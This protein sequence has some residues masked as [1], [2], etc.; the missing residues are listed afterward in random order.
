MKEKA[1]FLL[2]S[3]LMTG[4]VFATHL[5]G[6]EMNYRY[7]GNDSF[8]ITLK[9]YRD[10]YNGVA[11]FDNPAN[12][13][14]FDSNNN[15]YTSFEMP[16]DSINSIANV[17]NSP[18]L[19][20]PD[21]VCYEVGH[22]SQV[23]YLP[24]GVGGYQVAYQRCCR[25]YTII[26]IQNPGNVGSTIVANIPDLSFI[27]QDANPVFKN[28]P[29]TFIC[30]GAPFI[31]DH[32]ATDADGD[33]LMYELCLPYDG[34][35]TSVPMPSVPSPPP[36]NPIPY[37][38]P[39]SINNFLGGTPMTINPVTG[40][41]R[42][43]PASEG[44]FVYGICVK[45][46]RNGVYIGETRR[47]FQVNVTLCSNITVAG[48]FSP[49]VS[50]G[51]LTAS[52]LNLSYGAGFYSWSFGNPA[53][54]N[55]TS[56]A[57]NPSYSYTDTGTYH[58][59]LVAYSAINPLCNDTDYGVVYVYP[60]FNSLFSINNAR[61]S[62]FFYFNDLSYGIDGSA[63][64]WQWNFGDGYNIVG[65]QNPVHNY[66]SPGMYNVTLIAATDSGC[67]DTITKIINVLPVP[68][69]QF[70]LTLD[71]CRMQIH[72][73]NASTQSSNY[74]WNFGDGGNTLQSNNTYTY[75]S[76][77]SFTIQLIA[78]SDS[79]CTD[80]SYFSI[81]IPQV[82]IPDFT[83]SAANCDSVV[84]FTNLSLNSNN[85]TWD[86][87]D[88][89]YAY[90]TNPAHLY[91]GSGPYTVILHA[92]GNGAS[93]SN[94]FQMTFTL[95]RTPVAHFNPLLDTCTYKVNIQNQSLFASQYSWWISDGAVTLDNNSSHQFTSA[96]TY[97]IQMIANSG[98]G[99]TDTDTAVI[100]IP[101][102]ARADYSIL[103][104]VCDSAA[105]FVNRSGNAVSYQWSFGD[106]TTSSDDNPVQLVATSAH[107]CRDTLKKNL[108]LL[109]R[110]PADFVFFT[111]TCSSVTTFNNRSPLASTFNWDFGDSKQSIESN[112]SH[113][114]RSTKNY[115]V[116]FITNEG[117]VCEEKTEKE[118]NFEVREGEI[119]SIPNSFTPN[120][121]GHNDVFRVYGYR[122]CEV[123][124]MSIFDR[125]GERVFETEDALNSEWDGSFRGAIVPE[126]VYVY[127]LT[128]KTI[129]RTGYIV[130]V[131]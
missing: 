109:F 100:T 63:D 118:L 130:V 41:V 121:D 12:I 33:S 80:T 115:T 68:H 99:C 88:L 69:S 9:I 1:L 64:F 75:S 51:T 24:Q 93:C 23:V 42:A 57:A 3:I 83:Y 15:L 67:T 81:A 106:A 55:D 35:S 107:Q 94:D 60:K 26:N 48:I 66:I 47:E 21:N 131:K 28:L 49:T 20:P 44:Q 22:Y 119:I 14:V 95:N 113:I 120:K 40:Q 59:Q 11:P 71:T 38:S 27:G 16:L 52:F 104:A 87:G 76:N 129:N 53:T 6:G 2:L 85:Y 34:A 101:P 7:L 30:N 45:E 124:S 123:Y 105:N 96:G 74:S 43:V 102:K 91:H 65:T 117:T 19:I 98:T 4:Q 116:T 128:A 84:H 78:Q 92:V 77:G 125:W 62:D 29:P 37:Q 39:Y 54:N 82:P 122:P 13:G 70:S 97:S 8:E 110:A 73:N 89:S 103:L 72:I 108:D 126:G 86:F 18:C 79:G 46:Y 56:S 127:T 25:N 32:S 50:C 111:D 17:V 90:N 5:V 36:Y 61:C 58:V 112:P 31:F 114:Y 10:C